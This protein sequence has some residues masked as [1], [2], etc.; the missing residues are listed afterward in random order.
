MGVTVTI[1]E[2]VETDGNIILASASPR[3]RALLRLLGMLPVVEPADVDENPVP[4]ES[5][6]ALTT[7]LA[8]SKALATMANRSTRA[9]GPEFFDNSRSA[10]G[11]GRDDSAGLSVDSGLFASRP[12]VLGADTVVVLVDAILGKPADEAEARAM[13][14]ALRG[15]AHRVLTGVALAADGQI[16]WSTVVETTVWMR[17]YGADEVERYVRSGKPLDKAG[18]YGIQD[19]D[20]HPVERIEGCFSNVVGL[21]ICEVRRALTALDPDRSWG[22]S[23][24]AATSTESGDPHALCERARD[25]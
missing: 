13:L 5:P 12:I 7:R 8:R 15:R 9:S 17:A 10:T 21:P 1:R 16:A 6:E 22:P 2:S 14:A 18:A 19:A 23:W 20:F 24:R 11:S 3:R 25:L 4:G